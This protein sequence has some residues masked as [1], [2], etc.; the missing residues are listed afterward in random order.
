[1]E[2]EEKLVRSGIGSDVRRKLEKKIT[3]KDRVKRQEGN[4]EC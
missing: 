1:M 4:I 3:K 2:E